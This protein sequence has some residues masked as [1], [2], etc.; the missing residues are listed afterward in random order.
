MQIPLLGWVGQMERGFKRIAM[1]GFKG[2]CCHS[3]VCDNF[4]TNPRA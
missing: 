4:T 2:V 3:G 1:H